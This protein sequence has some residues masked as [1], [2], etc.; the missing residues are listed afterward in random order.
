MNQHVIMHVPT[1]PYPP[2][3]WLVID[4][5]IGVSS[6]RV[7]S[8]VKKLT[9]A[10]K[11]GHGGTLD[12]LASGLLPI[13]LGEATKLISY[14]M[15]GSKTYQF[16]IT[17]GEKR[18]TDDAEG[19]VTATSPYIPSEA[20]V[21]AAL[22]HFTGKILQIPPSYSALKVGGKRAYALAR[23]GEAVTLPPRKVHIAKLILLDYG[24][25]KATLE[26]VCGKGTY[27]RSLARDLA[28]YMG[29]CGYV[30]MLRRTQVGKFT[31]NHAILLDKLEEMV[32]NARRYDFLLSVD[33]VLDGIPV[34]VIT[35]EEAKRIRHGQ[36]VPLP[37]GSATLQGVMPVMAEGRLV[38]LGNI[39][40]GAVKPVRVFN[41]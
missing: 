11:V 25:G 21:Q 36:I 4:K 19:A 35:Q 12:P 24:E 1:L 18:D 33:K 40:G 8:Q 14:A 39:T 22:P 10:A 5:P 31:L 41:I 2:S 26:V 23:A 6:A 29:A 9:K 30:S 7:V 15:D 13:A 16:T 27:I 37:P 17:F 38:A 34:L 20:E 3:G 32:H 28:K